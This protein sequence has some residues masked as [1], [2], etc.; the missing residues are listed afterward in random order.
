MQSE[1]NRKTVCPATS[2]AKEANGD[3][4][5]RMMM[6]YRNN[7]EEV[8]QSASQ[9]RRVET[10]MECLSEIRHGTPKNMSISFYYWWKNNVVTI[11]NTSFH[12]FSTEN[13]TH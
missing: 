1:K 13:F 12:S 3:T 11:E 10:L 4:G 9:L 8:E 2:T 6:D 7:E 5:K